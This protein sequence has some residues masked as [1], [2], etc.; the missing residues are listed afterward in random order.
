MH[1]RV[2]LPY[3][4]R[5]GRRVEAEHRG[6]M[7]DRAEALSRLT[8]HALRGGVGCDQLRKQRFESLKL[9]QQRVVRRIANRRPI[10]DV[11]AV[12]V[13]ADLASECFDALA[14][15]CRRETMADRCCG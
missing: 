2:E 12:V 14:R 5:V 3:H 1:P 4:V 11:V 8:S 7:R 15:L 10:E 9:L 13:M 6:V